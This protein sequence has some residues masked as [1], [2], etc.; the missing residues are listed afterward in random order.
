MTDGDY[1]DAAEK[2]SYRSSIS[3]KGGGSRI[4]VG[5]TDAY[6]NPERVFHG[7]GAKSIRSY[8]ALGRLTAAVTTAPG[9]TLQNDAYIWRTDGLLAERRRGAT[10]VIA[11]REERLAHDGLGR[12]TS[13]ETR[14]GGAASPSRTL[15]FL[16]D[17][18]G[19]LESRRSDIAGEADAELSYDP[20][21]KDTPR[22]LASA[23]VGDSAW[24]IGHDKARR[25]EAY[26]SATG[27]GRFVEWNGQG[28]P[29]REEYAYGP[30]GERIFR[31]TTWIGEG[32]AQ[33]TRRTY[34]G[35]GS[36][37]K[38]LVGGSALHL[39]TT[40]AMGSASS[41]WEYLHADHLGSPS[42]VTDADGAEI[43]ALSHDPYGSRRRADWTGAL[44]AG[45]ADGQDRRTTRGYGGH[46]QLDRTGFVHMGG[47]LYD[48]ALG[49]FLSPD[50]VVARPWGSQG[51][52]PYS[53]AGNAPLSYVD[54]DGLTYCL[55]YQCVRV[56]A[57]LYG[58]GFSVQSMRVRSL[59]VVHRPVY[60]VGL[61]WNGDIGG[62]PSLRVGMSWASSIAV[63]VREV[64]RDVAGAFEPSPADAPLAGE[65]AK[66]GLSVLL[67]G[68][69]L[70]EC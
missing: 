49:R 53:Y 13:V 27:E 29:S 38:T 10:G 47:R 11:A 35:G 5:G 37:E 8:D 31:R 19:N 23:T 14:I 3:E 43:A 64:L 28:L 60:G 26:K 25:I 4:A 17:A 68:Y 22:R 67:P 44:P 7:S 18:L 9:R 69:D 63:S 59:S 61:A 12:L 36:V 21:G 16:H 62:L 48:P 33:R 2:C 57:E 58:G 55:A 39:R 51:W 45:I 40:P 1:L 56:S 20:A 6:G 54:P 24:S 32:G 30:D 65:L 46:E 42:S 15:S 52:N 41:T 66:V 34:Y 70:A 50:P